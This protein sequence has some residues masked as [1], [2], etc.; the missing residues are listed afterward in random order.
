MCGI[1]AVF[2]DTTDIDHTRF[3]HA[4]DQLMYRG[5]DDSGM[6]VDTHCL[7]GHRRLSI[8]DL[9][10]GGHQPMHTP[11]GR[12]HIVF[13]G[14]IYNYKALRSQLSSFSFQT[15]SDTE[16]LLAAYIAYGKDMVNH[17]DG[18]FAFA[19]YDSLEKS[20]FVARDPLGIKPLVY[21]MRNSTIYIASE[22]KAIRALWDQQLSLDRASLF[23]FFCLKHIPAPYSIF[24]EI[25][26]LPAGCT[27]FATQDHILDPVIETYWRPTYDPDHHT[28]FTSQ[29]VRE[30][31][32][33]T[34]QAHLVADVPVGAFLSGG[35]DS[36]AIVWAMREC[37]IQPKTYTVGFRSQ[38]D[39]QDIISAR[40]IAKYFH[41]DHHE[42]VVDGSDYA[43]VMKQ[44]IYASDE[45]FADPAMASNWYVARETAKDA[46]VVLSGDGGDEVFFGYPAYQRMNSFV[47]RSKVRLVKRQDPMEY[48][49][50]Y[51][52]RDVSALLGIPTQYPRVH[53]DETEAPALAMRQFDLAKTLPDYYLRKTDLTSMLHSLE[54]R[55]PFCSRSFVEAMERI[56]YR[57]HMDNTHGKNVLREAFRGFIP[58]DIIDRPKQGFSRPV[59]TLLD[60]NRL[61]QIEKHLVPTGL[62]DSRQLHIVLKDALT[63]QRS[64]STAWK[65]FVFSEWYSSQ[66]LL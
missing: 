11:D 6:F 17:L 31:F 30:L 40:R 29:R 12:Y 55:V 39:D 4:R 65:L 44:I 63:H 10:M 47:K 36:S 7:L 8:I 45:P 26:K 52:H 21:A 5:P 48:Y 57:V 61:Q 38:S 15:Q 33:E 22:I 53:Y 27:L 24:Q 9:S 2:G 49:F 3:E 37:G 1:L 34:V 46:T 60:A 43:D 28:P 54:V 25:K 62:F 59:H 18:M 32:L 16:V 58:D 13:N 19:I 14:E 23:D 42:Y 64:R 35:I 66:Y 56:S 51:R 20:L 41:T 50:G